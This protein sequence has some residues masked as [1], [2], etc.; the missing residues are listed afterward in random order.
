MIQND[1][2][3]I[4]NKIDSVHGSG[5]WFPIFYQNFLLGLEFKY[6]CYAACPSNLDVSNLD[7][8]TLMRQSHGRAREIF[9]FFKKFFLVIYPVSTV[10]TP[11]IGAHC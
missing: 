11:I 6:Y 4:P 9:Q 1:L 2:I 7:V 10:D 3:Y 5:L 8:T